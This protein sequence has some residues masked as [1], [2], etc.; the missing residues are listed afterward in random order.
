MTFDPLTPSRRPLAAAVDT[1]DLVRVD[2]DGDPAGAFR[3][4]V[5]KGWAAVRRFAAPR[6]GDL[7][8]VPIGAFA[9]M[10]DPSSPV[11][12]I[13]KRFVGEHVRPLD[14]LVRDLT[15]EGGCVL[16]A[17]MADGPHGP[18][19][20]IAVLHRGGALGLRV[21]TAHVDGGRVF[22]VDAIASERLFPLVHE[23]I[24]PC[25][26]SFALVRPTGVPWLA[27]SQTVCM[28]RVRLELPF[29]WRWRTMA[30]GRAL[31]G[32]PREG[33]QLRALV[34]LRP[35]NLETRA[36]VLARRWSTTMLRSGMVVA[37]CTEH[38]GPTQCAD[39]EIPG[40]AID[41]EVRGAM[42]PRVLTVATRRIDAG[43]LDVAVL[44]PPLR[45][46]VDT[47]LR[48][49]GLLELA[50]TTAT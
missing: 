47:W 10:P 14:L 25:G 43:V 30:D 26:P 35:A 13:T 20:Q 42:G 38:R 4:L 32:R 50:L 41:L 34:R 15:A 21:C 31:D 39:V 16:G 19:L 28:G 8:P 46:D 7:G 12:V 48:V 27:R 2:V 29:D 6:R 37:S 11:L 24:A 17:T 18:R 36:D 5:P 33:S 40:T 23:L 22:A 9:A 44:A 1:H 49:R 3:L 45:D